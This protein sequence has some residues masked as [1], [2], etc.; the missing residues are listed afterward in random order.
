[1]A[2]ADNWIPCMYRPVNLIVLLKR[3]GIK[4][5]LIFSKP[6]GRFRGLVDSDC[7]E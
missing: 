3:R 4:P 1:V 6:L 7:V 2:A 5:R